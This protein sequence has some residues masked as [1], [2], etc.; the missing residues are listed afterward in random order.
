MQC[1]PI[2]VW[3]LPECSW[4]GVGCVGPCV[5]ALWRTR[6]DMGD[7]VWD[8][9]TW[10]SVTPCLSWW[11]RNCQRLVTVTHHLGHALIS[12]YLLIGKTAAGMGLCERSCC[13]W[14]SLYFWMLWEQLCTLCGSCALTGLVKVTAWKGKAVTSQL[15]TNTGHYLVTFTRV[16]LLLEHHLKA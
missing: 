10:L 2:P 6:G 9:R 13:G 8:W 11:A 3:H 16:L 12:Y 4:F 15:M 1:V 14:G 5:L 7:V